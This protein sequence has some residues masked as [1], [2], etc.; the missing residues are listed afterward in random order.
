MKQKYFKPLF[1][2]TILSGK[3]NQSIKIITQN[4]LT[5]L[6]FFSKVISY[7]T[8]PNPKPGTRNLEPETWNLKPGTRNFEPG[9]LNPEPET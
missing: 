8:T 9:T 5:P 3:T 6:I 7:P 4:P 1:I 2:I